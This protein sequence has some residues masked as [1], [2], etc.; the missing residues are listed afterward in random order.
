MSFHNLPGV[1]EYEELL[2]ESIIN[3]FL[4]LHYSWKML[5]FIPDFSGSVSKSLSINEA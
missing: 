5:S 4:T 2:Q 1:L 3:F